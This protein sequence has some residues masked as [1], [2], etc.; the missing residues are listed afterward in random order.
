MTA[1]AI[2][3]LSVGRQCDVLQDARPWS[4]FV[5][6]AAGKEAG[7]TSSPAR[8]QHGDS[9]LLLLLLSKL[10]F[11]V[12]CNCHVMSTPH[13][14]LPRVALSVCSAVFENWF[15]LPGSV[16]SPAQ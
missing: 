3:L 11:S 15:C 6:A 8:V 1:G 16:W 10:I 12:H 9:L 2:C 13:F 4:L 7:T 14:M 5:P